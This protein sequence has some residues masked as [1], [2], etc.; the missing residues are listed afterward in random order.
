MEQKL[1]SKKGGIVNIKDELL[2]KNIQ[3]AFVLMGQHLSELDKQQQFLSFLNPF[4]ITRYVKKVPDVDVLEIESCLKLYTES[5]A[6][7][8]VAIGGGSVMDLAKGII[9]RLNEQGKTIPYYIAVPT[10]TGSGSEA[11]CFAVVYENKIKLSLQHACIR[12]AMAILDPELTLSLSPLQTAIP[13]MDAFSQ[14]V[15]SYWNVFAT[16]QSQAWAKEAITILNKYLPGAVKEADV[17]LREK[18]LRAAH[19]AGKAIN[20]TRTTGPHALSYYLTARYGVPHG[21]AVS[22]F[23]PV[24][25]LYNATVHSGNCNHAAGPEAVLKALNELYGLLG[26]KNAEDAAQYIRSLMQQLGLATT[27]QE[28]SIKKEGIWQPL[29]NEINEQRFNNN[30]VLLNRK[31]LEELCRE[32]L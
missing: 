3:S 22:L 11:T 28:L 14:A 10:T 29:L 8:I 12:P 21:Q 32:H 25:F 15:E 5:G 13:G 9:Y 16:E 1:V 4:A 6:H 30:P 27:L 19:I 17:E 31:L 20:I 7:A 24:F 2:Q 23:L 26:V 18:I